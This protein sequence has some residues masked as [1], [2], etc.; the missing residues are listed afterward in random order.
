MTL[1]LATDDDVTNDDM[2]I[3]AKSLLD[4]M[5][6]ALPNLDPRSLQT[7]CNHIDEAAS[8]I[9]SLSVC[10]LLDDSYSYDLC[11]PGG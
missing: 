5:R 11:S 8:A 6:R 4:E 2:L 7:A 9:C 3:H 1:N 10:H